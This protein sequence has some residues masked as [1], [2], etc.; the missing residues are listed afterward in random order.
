MASTEKTLTSPYKYDDGS[1]YEGEF[2]GMMRHGYGVYKYITGEVYE[3]QWRFDKK[4]GFGVYKFTSGGIYEGEW[5]DGRKTGKGTFKFPSGDVYEGDWK[6]DK[7]TGFGI[8]QYNN[9][10][11]YEGWW[12][13]DHKHGIGFYRFASNSE[14]IGEW[15]FGTKEG[16]GRFHFNTNDIYEGQWRN[17]KREGFGI[18]FY[19]REG[20]QYIGYWRSDRKHGKGVY[21]Y[22]NGDW[23]YGDWYNGEKEGIGMFYYADNGSQYLGH[24]HRNQ[25]HGF[26]IY[27]FAEGDIY[28]GDWRYDLKDGTGDYYYATGDRY[29]GS[30]REDTKSAEGIY[31][32]ANNDIYVSYWTNGMKNDPT[33]KFYPHDNL[34]IVRIVNF[35]MGNLD[36]IVEEKKIIE[37]ERPIF[38]DFRLETQEKKLQELIEIRKRGSKIPPYVIP[39]SIAEE[40]CRVILQARFSCPPFVLLINPEK[41]EHDSLEE[42]IWDDDNCELQF[43]SKR[44]TQNEAELRKKPIS[45][46]NQE[47]SIM[48]LKLIGLDDL[49]LIFQ[50]A[51]ISGKDLI[52]MDNFNLAA[53]GITSLGLRI[54]IIHKLREF[55][56]FKEL[57]KNED[58]IFFAKKKEKLSKIMD[59]ENLNPNPNQNQNQ[60]QNQNLDLNLNQNQ[61]QNPNLILNLNIKRSNP[62]GTKTF[63]GDFNHYLFSKNWRYNPYAYNKEAF[64][65]TDDQI[66]VP[67][68]LIQ[69]FNSTAH[70]DNQFSIQFPEDFLQIDEKIPQNF[71]CPLT[72]QIMNDPV[73]ADDGRTY[74]RNAIL[75]WFKN[76]DTS[77]VYKEMK[78][79]STNLIPNLELKKQIQNFLQKFKKK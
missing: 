28:K 36:S 22:R 13:E 63:E 16:Y 66:E 55:D 12:F 19:G 59:L 32:H 30:W 26:G 54:K 4:H 14:Y 69:P 71:I 37:K 6:D 51:R 21:I 40:S 5:V 27:H 1:I 10:D 20:D 17:E 61:N 23:Y 15:V 52:Y 3:G 39:K 76:H 34:N 65:S 7:R 9:G 77:P 44:I 70:F 72:N 24:W 68:N 64:I 62:Y 35:E 60:N 67:P 38:D 25:R 57:T 29:Q 31:F 48:F 2:K 79:S 75:K 43:K 41:C 53:L 18:Y 56:Q 42:Y 50:D 45:S 47:N 8:Y 33:A 49:I 46:W 58:D 73:I 11:K 78:L 74:E